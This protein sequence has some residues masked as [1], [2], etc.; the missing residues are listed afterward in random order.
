MKFFYTSLTIFI[1]CSFCVCAQVIK[2]PLI[3][4]NISPQEPL[5]AK[6]SPNSKKILFSRN[7][8]FASLFVKDIA[9]GEEIVSEKEKGLD[10]YGYVMASCY[11]PDGT[12]ILSAGMKTQMAVRIEIIWIWDA[13][14]GIIK[15]AYTTNA[16]MNLKGTVQSLK[17]DSTGTLCLIHRME[18]ERSIAE[19][20]NWNTGK[21]QTLA[22]NTD[23]EYVDFDRSGKKIVILKKNN[24]SSAEIWNPLNG[25]RIDAFSLSKFDGYLKIAS[26][27]CSGETIIVGTET[28]SIVF[29]DTKFGNVISQK[30]EH[31]SAI[32]KIVHEKGCE[33]FITISN[34][35][36]AKVWDAGTLEVLAR[37][38][39]HADTLMDVQFSPNGNYIITGSK[40]STACIWDSRTGERLSRMGKY[41]GSVNTAQFS[42]TGDTVLV[43]DDYGEVHMYDVSGLHP[44]AVESELYESTDNTLYVSLDD[45]NLQLQFN[46]PVDKSVKYS[47]VN[48]VGE[49]VLR[50]NVES[51]NTLYEIPIHS[52]QMGW[53]ILVSEINGR[54]VQEKFVFTN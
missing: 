21:R 4:M 7:K 52:L 5:Y 18:N 20:W 42:V 6:F 38:G 32:R 33:R 29:A 23:V 37:L 49:E 48:Y 11:N 50:G 30:K 31:T 36:T 9:T 3:K 13:K 19:I 12:Y 39:G 53:Y 24:V 25:E 8:A 27:T 40:D 34:D 46:K 54:S 26:F 41:M 43:S 15:T 35:N 44:S 10:P 2:I 47:I 17:Y 22:V 16:D 1:L 45:N 14:S 51:G 28:G